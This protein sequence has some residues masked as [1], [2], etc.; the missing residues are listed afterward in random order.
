MPKARQ[1]APER[2][3]RAKNRRQ[4]EKIVSEIVSESQI[5]EEKESSSSYIY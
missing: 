2:V 5:L 4:K 1:G 3:Q